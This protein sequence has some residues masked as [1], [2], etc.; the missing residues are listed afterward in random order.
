M[1]FVFIGFSFLCFALTYGQNRISV[2][3]TTLAGF[4]GVGYE[5]LIASHYSFHVDAFGSAFNSYHNMPLKFL[6]ITP[7]I[8]WYAKRKGTGFYLGAHIGGSIF[9][10]QKYNYQ[11]TNL[12]Q[13]GL[14]YQLGV[15]VGY[16]YPIS[17]GIALEAF[18]GG[19]S[20]QSFYKGYDTTT[21][22]RYDG[23]KKFN[24]SGEWLPYR[25]GVTVIFLL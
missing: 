20:V 2:N 6:S 9:E 15:S 4:P 11:N 22:N 16:V 1:K 25:G 8:R 18:V 5:R 3:G 7:E 17:E 24:K 13:K 21:G 23:A 10:L 14:A 19:G 12:Y